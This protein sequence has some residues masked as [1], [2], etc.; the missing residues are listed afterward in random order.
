MVHNFGSILFSVAQFWEY[1]GIKK[2]SKAMVLTE[3]SK[4][5]WL[6]GVKEDRSI[7]GI[8]L[9]EAKLLLR[10]G[11]LCSRGVY[12]GCADPSASP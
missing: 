5:R 3:R 8:T 11:G 12:I 9:H 4:K 1:R 7:Q 6:N 2:M 10:D